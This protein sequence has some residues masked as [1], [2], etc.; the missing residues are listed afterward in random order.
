MVEPL[1]W[2]AVSGLLA[3]PQ[4]ILDYYL[5]CLDESGGAP[6]ELKRVRQELRQVEKQK[7]RLL[8]AYQAEIIELD[9][10]ATRRQALE[11]QRQV[12]A[13]RLSELEQLA[14]QQARQEALTADVLAFCENIN[15]VLQSPTPEEKQQVLRLVVDHILVG[16]EQL[17]IKHVVP[18][19]GDRRLH[20]QRSQDSFREESRVE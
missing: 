7:Q 5:A 6:H 1:I 16:K 3:D 4:L 12:L 11:Q 18:L 14:H 10:L 2:Q 20:T 19:A 8:D 17:I 13:I 15:S 9:E